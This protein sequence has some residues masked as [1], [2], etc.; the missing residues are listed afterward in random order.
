MSQKKRKLII[1]GIIL[2][3]SGVIFKI[4]ERNKNFS[5][6]RYIDKIEKLKKRGKTDKAIKYLEGF[7]EKYKDT[8][9]YLISKE[10]LV[11]IY[12][13][14]EDWE[15]AKKVIAKEI[16]KNKPET[17]IIFYNNTSY[18][19]HQNH[20]H[21][22]AKK[23]AQ[24]IITKYPQSSLAQE[25]YESLS[26]SLFFEKDFQKAYEKYKIYADDTEQWYHN[27]VLT[28][29]E[30]YKLM[31]EEKWDE[32]ILKFNK[33]VKLVKENKFYPVDKNYMIGR[34]VIHIADCYW[35]KG[36]RQQALKHYQ[37][38]QKKFNDYL[39]TS[40]DKKTI[41]I[42][43]KLIRKINQHRISKTDGKVKYIID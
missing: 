27:V 29:I 2:L 40:Q 7:P 10:Q 19:L 5:I 41:K 33:F 24:K 30:A 1:I 12:I 21:S 43:Q 42:A 37:A 38:S 11:N 31:H 22:E 16:E 6:S 23:L 39:K 26:V 25:A 36:D 34:Q 18:E 13:E 3:I 32:A 15:K 8:A 28:K 35:N 9:M 14:R 17:I 20:R 4:H